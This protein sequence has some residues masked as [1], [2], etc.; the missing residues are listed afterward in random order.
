MFSVAIMNPP[1]E[2]NLHLKIMEKVSTYTE[3]VVNISPTRWIVDPLAKYKKSSDFNRF[4]HSILNKLENLEIYNARQNK[5]FFENAIMTMDFGIY[6]LGKGGFD[7]V[8]LSS[9]KILDKVI[10]KGQ[11]NIEFNKKDG[12]RVRIPMILPNGKETKIYIGDFDKNIMGFGKLLYFYNGM[13]DNKY[14]YNFY[15]RNQFS[16]TTEE[17]TA[18]IRFNSEDECKNFIDSLQNTNVGR[19]ITNLVITDVHISNY[20]IM[21]TDD[22]S[23][24]WTDELLCEYFGITNDEYNEILNFIHK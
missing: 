20:S 12:W 15:G 24:P 23:H 9:N 10:A 1:Y 14:W 3:K 6:V 22:Y 17:I 21:W 16:K 19:Y 2:R 18:S 8:K 7:Y 11:C 4:K 5:K 13:K